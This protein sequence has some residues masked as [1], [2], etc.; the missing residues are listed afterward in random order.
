MPV[1]PNKA[2]VGSNA[3]SHSSGI[4]QDGVLKARDTYEIVTP[5]SVGFN[6]NNMNLTARSGRHIIKHRLEV[7]GYKEGSYNLDDVYNRF[8]ELADIKGQVFDYDLE[9]L[10]FFSSLNE[11]PEEFKIEYMT[12]LSGGKNVLP[13]ASMKLNIG[14]KIV[15]DSCIGNGPVDAIYQCIYRLTGYN[16]SLQKYEIKSKGQGKDALGQVDIIVKYEDKL[17]HGMGL[18]TD[19]IQSSAEA[20]IHACNSI[21]RS[22]LV[23]IEKQKIHQ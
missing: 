18:A 5:E 22:K 10:L 11:E 19:I 6:T 16:I 12:V 17:F 15:T 21:Y 23:E 20:M 14:G 8:K 1:P 13:T 3:F 7:M 9:A 4:H 2:I